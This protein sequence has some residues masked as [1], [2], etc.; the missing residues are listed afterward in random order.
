[1]YEVTMIR[2][3]VIISDWFIESI[4]LQLR[5]AVNVMQM[6]IKEMDVIHHKRSTASYHKVTGTHVDQHV[7]PGPQHWGPAY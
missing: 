1:M 7:K 3:T 2:M 5:L 6:N 4:R